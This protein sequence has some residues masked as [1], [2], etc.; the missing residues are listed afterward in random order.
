MQSLWE[1]LRNNGYMHPERPKTFLDRFAIEYRFIRYFWKPQTIAIAN[2][3][4]KGSI[5]VKFEPYR[6]VVFSHNKVVNVFKPKWSDVIKYGNNSP[7]DGAIERIKQLE[8]EIKLER[9]C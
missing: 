5:C 8:L 4:S 7:C 2:K 9:L 3:L 1:Y 6:F